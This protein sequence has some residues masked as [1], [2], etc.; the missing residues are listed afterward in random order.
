MRE[1]GDVRLPDE[2][3]AELVEL[4]LETTHK[5]VW[6]KVAIFREINPTDDI[7]A[8]IRIERS[9]LLCIEHFR[10]D[11][12]VARLLGGFAFFFKRVLGFAERKQAFLYQAKI[13]IGERRQFFK[14]RAAG[15]VEI[16]QQGRRTSHVPRIGRA[17]K[18]PAPVKELPIQARLD[19]KRRRGIPHPSEAECDDAR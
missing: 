3:H 7:H 8:W 17:P 6:A 5:A 10:R 4:H 13:I 12:E 19:V 18:F 9:G 11:T 15:Q 2:L 14:T 16:T 1:T